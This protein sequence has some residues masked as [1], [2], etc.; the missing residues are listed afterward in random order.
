MISPKKIAE[1][2]GCDSDRM[3]NIIAKLMK[4]YCIINSLQDSSRFLTVILV[5]MLPVS[6]RETFPLSDACIHES[7]NCWFTVSTKSISAVVHYGAIVIFQIHCI[8]FH[9]SKLVLI[10]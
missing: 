6:A 10:S 7:G 2:I 1:S 9:F 3:S 8:G 5:H 4:L